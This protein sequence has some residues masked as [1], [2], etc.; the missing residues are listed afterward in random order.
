LRFAAGLLVVGSAD[1]VLVR[2][3]KTRAFGCWRLAGEKEKGRVGLEAAKWLRFRLGEG[4]PMVTPKQD[5]L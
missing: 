3:N 1:F 5:D 4:S 2:P